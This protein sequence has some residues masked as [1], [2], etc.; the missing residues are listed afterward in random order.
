[1]RF[2]ALNVRLVG[3]FLFILSFNLRILAEEG[4]KPADEKENA[5]VL[6]PYNNPGEY[7][8]GTNWG[9][10][11]ERE[12]KFKPG[13]E[14]VKT[15]NWYKVYLVKKLKFKLTLSNRQINFS[16][17]TEENDEEGGDKESQEFNS[18]IE[19]LDESGQILEEAIGS[20][21]KKQ[22]KVKRLMKQSGYY[23][24]R[25]T[26][27]AGQYSGKSNLE[28]WVHNRDDCD[29]PIYYTCR[30]DCDDCYGSGSNSCSKCNNKCDKRER[31]RLKC[32]DRTNKSWEN[33]IESLPKDQ[34]TNPDEL[35]IPS[36][37]ILCPVSNPVCGIL[38]LTEVECPS[39]EPCPMESMGPD[40]R[41]LHP[42]IYDDN[43]KLQA[44]GAFKIIMEVCNVWDESLTIH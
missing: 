3:L 31:K 40:G 27:P 16:N 2:F 28:I 1:M 12:T 32:N 13:V 37:S 14:Q 19:F 41:P 35:Y 11:D 21:R 42:V 34:S 18:K 5:C 33:I 4:C 44:A 39:D 8:N 30:N 7:L 43:C 15:V 26:F 38:P 17:E 9:R 20:S 36:D 25:V 24:I 23:Y 6:N 10:Y 29:T 22:L